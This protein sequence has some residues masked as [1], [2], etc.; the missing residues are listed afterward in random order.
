MG[1]GEREWARSTRRRGSALQR[2][3]QRVRVAERRRRWRVNG[4]PPG[5]GRVSKRGVRACARG[6]RG[7]APVSKGPVPRL[8]P[9]P[10]DASSR[11]PHARTRARRPGDGG[12]QLQRERG[13]V[14]VGAPSIH[15]SLPSPT[16]PTLRT[17]ANATMPESS[18]L[19]HESTDRSRERTALWAHGRGAGSAVGASSPSVCV[20]GG[21]CWLRLGGGMTGERGRRAPSP[22]RR[23]AMRRDRRANTAAGGTLAPPLGRGDVGGT[24]GAHRCRWGCPWRRWSRRG[25]ES[26]SSGSGGALFHTACRHRIA[27]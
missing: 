20:G 3:G 25:R 15:P 14:L 12:R 11:A 8:D 26:G 22:R 5:L 16:P 10:P 6:E 24:A 27:P 18:R 17:S 9:S 4:R 7:D 23:G 19:P 21:C 1:R 2:A 13:R